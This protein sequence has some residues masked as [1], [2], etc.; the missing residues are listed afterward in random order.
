MADAAET[1]TET[2]QETTETTT[3]TK[4]TESETD[5][6][7]EAQ[8]WKEQSQKQ[9]QRAKANAKAA[10]ELEEFR[11]SSMSD[12]EKAV[13]EAEA[14]GRTTALQE[15]GARLVDA[16]VRVAAAGRSADVDALLEGLDRT[17]FLT[18]DGEPDSDAIKAWVDR[19]APAKTETAE[20]G[21]GPLT[22][23]DLGQ[24]SRE[25]TPIGDDAAF[26]RMLSDMA[27]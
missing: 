15:A 22:A 17:K 12:Q 18:D 10:K 3:E 7:A 1:A 4:Q 25:S 26:I 13:A 21:Q 20:Q 19:I 6:Q 16:E 2:T 11:T 14:R 8:K 24:G 5:W 27:G 23:I 9:E